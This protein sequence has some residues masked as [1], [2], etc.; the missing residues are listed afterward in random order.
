MAE[1]LKPDLSLMLPDIPDDRDACVGRLTQ[2][3]PAEG[4][5]KVH[6]A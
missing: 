3:L 4:L 1:K 5:G 2:L 6:V